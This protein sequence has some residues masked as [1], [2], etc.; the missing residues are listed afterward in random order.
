MALIFL[1]ARLHLVATVPVSMASSKEQ[2]RRIEIGRMRRGA[3]PDRKVADKYRS[4]P[5]MTWKLSKSSARFGTDAVTGNTRTQNELT[6]A[7]ES[8]TN[9]VAFTTFSN[10]Q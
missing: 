5:S 6:S 4:D 9:P 10:D 8:L 1:G 2:G 3:E 7:L